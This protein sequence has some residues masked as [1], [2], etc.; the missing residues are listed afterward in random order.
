M[1]THRTANMEK[2]CFVHKTE[3][4]IRWWRWLI[5]C[6]RLIRKRWCLSLNAWK[7]ISFLCIGDE[8]LTTKHTV[9]FLKQH[10]KTQ[11]RTRKVWECLAHSEL[12]ASVWV[13]STENRTD[14]KTPSQY[15]FCTEIHDTKKQKQQRQLKRKTTKTICHYSLRESEWEKFVLFIFF[16]IC[17]PHREILCFDTLCHCRFIVCVYLFSFSFSFPSKNYY[18]K[19]WF[20]AVC[21]AHLFDVWHWIVFV[22]RYTSIDRIIFVI[23]IIIHWKVI[24]IANF[25]FKP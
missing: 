12:V 24:S 18:S 9:P 8:T 1:S 3:N 14:R 11:K 22:Q 10:K 4:D 16:V 20:R 2:N 6:E 19:S 25:R 23:I 21:S 17:V 7:S 13:Q 5:T 15:N